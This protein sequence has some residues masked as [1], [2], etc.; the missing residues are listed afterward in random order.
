[1]ESILIGV[2]VLLIMAM[3]K[4]MLRKTILDHYRDQLFD[5]R[6][7]LRATYV[8][9]GWDLASPMYQKLRTLVNGYLRFTEKFSV[10]QH[11]YLQ[12]EV[13]QSKSLQA[14]M[15]AEFEKDFQSANPTEQEFVRQFRTQALRVMIN[16][17]VVSSGPLLLI[18]IVLTPF[19]A[20]AVVLGLAG[21]GMGI[22]AVKVT[23][24]KAAYTSLLRF[25]IAAVGYR[26][27]SED[28][29]EEYSYRQGIKA[30]RS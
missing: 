12:W 23:E 22:L 30:V 21:R 19:A 28:F 1:M 24:A 20:F 13:S 11:T 29:V 15:K 17:M 2:N 4:F 6:D 26:V 18:S 5:L 25:V 16:Y 8:E 7:M 14:S 10:W 27:V 9:N 3:W